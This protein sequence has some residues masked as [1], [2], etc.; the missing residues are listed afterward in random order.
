MLLPSLPPLSWPACHLSGLSEHTI[1]IGYVAFEVE[2]GRL[3]ML[4]LATPAWGNAERQPLT[5]TRPWATRLRKKAESTASG[6][7][8]LQ[9]FS[10]RGGMRMEEWIGSFGNFEVAWRSSTLL[11]APP[12]SSGA[13]TLCPFRQPSTIVT[14]LPSVI[15]SPFSVEWVK[16]HR[17]LSLGAACRVI[18]SCRLFLRIHTAIAA[19]AAFN[20][21]HPMSF[22]SHQTVL[23]QQS[24]L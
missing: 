16:L 6:A 14:S 7:M 11:P 22:P 2:F 10:Q 8:G 12:Q 13:R 3:Y 21:Q 17:R 5:T 1:V 4:R 18:V 20:L 9:L 23:L 24:L 15:P 19:W